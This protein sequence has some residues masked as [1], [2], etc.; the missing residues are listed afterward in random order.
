MLSTPSLGKQAQ[1]AAKSGCSQ[2]TVGRI[3]NKQMDPTTEML[4]KLA[5]AFGLSAWQLLVPG[6]E[7]SN[8]PVLVPLSGKEK[9]FYD[10]LL[11]LFKEQA[12]TKGG[13]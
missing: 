1:V 5:G 4:E 7:P 11:G 6:L 9:A 2:T 3:L 13:A 10:R 12:S 8:P